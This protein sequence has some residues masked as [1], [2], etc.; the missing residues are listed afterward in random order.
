V[1]LG[2]FLLLLVRGRRQEERK[3]EGLRILR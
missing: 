2:A 3:Y 1:A